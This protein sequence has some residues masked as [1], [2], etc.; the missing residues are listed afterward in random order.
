MLAQH[1]SFEDVS[2]IAC[3]ADWAQRPERGCTAELFPRALMRMLIALEH[4]RQAKV[5]A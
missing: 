5:F 4:C 3:S 2:A 1:C